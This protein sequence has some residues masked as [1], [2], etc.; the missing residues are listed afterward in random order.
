VIIFVFFYSEGA[1]ASRILNSVGGINAVA[2]MHDTFQIHLPYPWRDILNIP[3][4]PVAAAITY[5]ALYSN[6]QCPMCSKFK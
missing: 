6:I 5:A 3:G 2:G 1:K 4:V